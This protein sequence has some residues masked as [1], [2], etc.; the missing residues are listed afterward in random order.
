MAKNHFQ[1]RKK[2]IWAMMIFVFVVFVIQLIN[3]Q[4]LNTS[5][6]ESADS[7]AFLKKI[8]YPARGLIYD[9]NGKLLVFNKPAY[10]VM[11]VISEV[12][13]FDTLDFCKTVNI[14]KEAFRRAI[15]RIKNDKNYNQYVPQTLL[16]QLSVEEYAVLQE[17]LFKFPG[18]YIQ[19]RTLR[20]YTYPSAAHALGSVGEVTKK[21]IEEDD[22]YVQGEYA[23]RNGVE[24][25]YEKVLRG[26]KGIEI[27]LRDYRGRIQ[28]RYE[29]GALDKTPVSGQNLT[30]SLDI[31]LQMYGEELMKG[32]IGSIVAI[33]PATGEILAL[34]SSPNFN[35]SDLVGRQRSKN[36][37]VLNND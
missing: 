26:K 16:S 17:K 11:V 34:V 24:K 2:V 32:K 6:K 14:S 8:Q 28:G 36:F 12:Q 1:E 10:D 5:F 33:E 35:P 37:D 20:E 23:G 7:N 15:R 27:L 22:Y 25:S 9:R 13:P 21:D 3:L 30:L 29:D 18:F 4:I 31:D 19:N